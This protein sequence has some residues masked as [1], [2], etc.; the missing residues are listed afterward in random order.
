VASTGALRPRMPASSSSTCTPQ[1]RPDKLLGW[2]NN[3]SGHFGNDPA[4]P[5]FGGNDFAANLDPG[6][7]S[8]FDPAYYATL[9]AHSGYWDPKSA[10]LLNMARIVDGQYS[11]VTIVHRVPH[12]APNSP[13]VPP[14]A[15]PGAPAPRPQ[16]SPTP[17]GG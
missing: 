8:G 3:Y 17:G 7:P 16:P 10:S 4:S 11:A 9:Q 6:K 13:P 1:F 15:G 5:Q 2:F 14:A 12:P